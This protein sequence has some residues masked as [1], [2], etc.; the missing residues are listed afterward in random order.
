MTEREI[1]I[2]A[3]DKGSPAERA[4]FLDAACAGDAALRGRVE[5][6][7][8][9][10]EG[11]GEF[12]NGSAPERLAGVPGVGVLEGETR[13]GPSEPDGDIPLHFLD[14]SD[15]PGSIG[16]LG[17]YEVQ[18]VVGRGGMGVVLKAFDERLHRV[19]AIKVMAPQLATSA[20]ARKRFVREARAQAA[21]T[22]DHVVT[23]H[24]VEDAGPLPY[25]VMQFVAGQ[26]LQDRLDRS[27]PLPL[28][29]ILRIGMQTAAGLAAA[30]AQ[31]LVH[32]DIKPSNILLENGVERVKLTD[33][34]LA[35]AADDASLTQ[36]GTVAGTPAFMS[37]EQAEGRPVD[38][39]SD[40]FS[41]G[42][43]LYAMC[44]GRPPFRASTSMAV[45]KRVCEET[46]TPIR[47]TNPEVPDWLAAVVEKLH[48]KNPWERYQS[49][50][51]VTEVL[52]RHLAHIQHP[53]VVPLSAV[54][55]TAGQ[56]PAPE[57]PARR[58]RWAVAAAVLMAMLAVLGTTEAT[59]VTNVR[60]TVIRIFTPD[61]TLV[62]ETDDPA[63]KVVVEGDGDLVI[64]GA[65]PQEVRLRAG[66]YRLKATRDGKPVKLD[67][68]LVAIT[69]GD[70]QIVRVRLEGETPAAVVPKAEPG[71]FVLMGGKGVAERKFDTLA[72]AVLGSADGDTI[73]VRGNGPFLTDHTE[74]RHAL[75][76][77]A[78]TG[79]RPVLT[80]V[81]RTEFSWESLLLSIAPLRLEGLEIHGDSKA[82]ILESHGP[83]WVANCRFLVAYNMGTCIGNDAACVIHNCEM[84]SAGAALGLYCDSEATSV[85]TNN[86]L[87]GQ[88]NLWERDLT[89][90]AT[91]QFTGN[92][93]VSAVNHTFLHGAFNQQFR[94]TDPLEK[95]V[96]LSVTNNVIACGSGPYGF[97]QLD[98]V[99]QHLSGKDAELWVRRRLDWRDEN[100]SYQVV[101]GQ[102]IGINSDGLF[103]WTS[104]KT[105]ADW[106]TFW[107]LKTTGSSEDVIRFLGGN[108]V[109][110]A[111]TQPLK[112]TAEDVRLRPDSAGYRAGKDKKDLGA[113][114]DLIGPG[115]AYERWKKTPDYQ[116]WLKKSGQI[117]K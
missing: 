58:H 21:V 60:A 31:G 103:H 109:S 12:L 7:L 101:G 92:T 20:T 45:L 29:E 54:A 93:L 113:D 28:A 72:E 80:E 71:A 106:N 83:L 16:R 97:G 23:I 63:V 35:R 51:E 11:A 91:F 19:V 100:N 47:E 26:S 56:P 68:D 99:R 10:H 14:P 69:Q 73:E 78:G 25:I 89:K 108:L 9:S 30:H 87:I 98:G 81:P 36:S 55:K 4:A 1:F 41:L 39:R 15:E 52:G 50:A 2:E 85:V 110:R 94:T 111:Q 44:T 88:V 48:A 102:W 107:G 77:R 42:S 74:F 3:L 82:S 62:V 34:G 104:Q 6:L 18:E 53:S 79:F 13:T 57:R 65:G 96:H 38:H 90:G 76:V 114:V 117:K 5:A 86:L 33:F 116:Q 32:R 70:R 22:H 61:G 49:A 43:V 105:L 64:T 17:H 59:G 46:P 115:K 27:G 8:R 112:L 24:A 66:N 37:S 40:L 75:T 67:R 84:V 95:R